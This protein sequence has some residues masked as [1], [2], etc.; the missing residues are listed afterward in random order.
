MNIVKTNFEYRKPLIPL[1]LDKVFFIVIHHLAAKT[2]TPSQI[3]QWHLDNGWLGFGYNEYIR[4]DGTVFIGRGD[5]IGAHTHG[6][7]SKSYGIAL[8]GN[9][10]EED[11]MTDEQFKSLIARVKY[12]QGRIK[13]NL[14]VVK[15]NKFSNTSCPGLYF[16]IEKVKGALKNEISEAVNILVEN[17]IINSPDYWL[18]NAIKGRNV[19]GEYAGILIKRVAE[20]IK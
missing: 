12:H 19:D 15:H 20:L 6:M 17:K 5:N 8:E 4:K 14:E 18:Q 2:A 10:D 3:H 7:N 1:D 16:S 9:F 11:D 13:N